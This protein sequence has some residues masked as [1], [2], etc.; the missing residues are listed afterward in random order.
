M[1]RES[2]YPISPIILNRWSARAMSGEEMSDEELMPLFEAARWAP[3][4]SNSQPWRFIYAKRNSKDW[5]KF[6]NLLVPG[7]Q[8]WAQKAAVLIIVA[9]KLKNDKGDSDLHTHSFDTGAAWENLAV[10]GVSRGLVVHAM[11]GFDYKKAAGVIEASSKEYAI[12]CMIAVGKKGRKED[13]PKRFVERET[14]SIRRPIQ[15][16]IFEGRLEKEGKKR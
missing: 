13:L 1:N 12:E 14:P 11:A 3:S 7:N 10:E 6:L 8:E 2:T 5:K 16:L 15:E 9:S 4:S